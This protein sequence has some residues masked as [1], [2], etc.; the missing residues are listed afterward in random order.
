MRLFLL[1]L[2]LIAGAAYLLIR[3]A[4]RGEVPATGLPAPAFELMDGAG[5]PQ[6]LSDYAGRWLV[7]YFYPKD[8]TPG[9]TAE[10]CALRDVHGEF[11]KRGVAVLGVS[12]DGTA[13]HAAFAAKH[14]LPFP[15][16]SDPEGRVARAYG[17]LWDFGVVRFA[18]RHTYLVD[19]LGRLARVYRS[20]SPTT[21]AAELLADIDRPRL[22][23]RPAGTNNQITPSP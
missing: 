15:L 11:G 5:R 3:W 13:S 12:L 6:R 2:L 23:G 18:K 9:C 4:G 1:L 10:A 8:D 22:E 16:L 21:H 17:A 19:P 20:V 7:L 14:R